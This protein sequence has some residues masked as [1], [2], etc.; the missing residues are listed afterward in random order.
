MYIEISYFWKEITTCDNLK[1]S[2]L[3]FCSKSIDH[4]HFKSKEEK[5]KTKPISKS[6]WKMIRSVFTKS[7]QRTTHHK[8]LLH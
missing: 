1:I 6:Q 5:D 4:M 7:K 2:R 8:S 3:F